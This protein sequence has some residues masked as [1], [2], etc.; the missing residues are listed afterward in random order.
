MERT[1]R[2]GLIIGALVG[3]LTAASNWDG[4]IQGA[5]SVVVVA[6]A[7]GWLVGYLMSRRKPR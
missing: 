4:H 6:A 1:G 2:N 3:C 5:F 7:M